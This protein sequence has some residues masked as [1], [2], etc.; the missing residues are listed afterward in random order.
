M[1]ERNPIQ[2]AVRYALTAGVAAS[3]AGVPA[4]V[5]AQTEIETGDVSGEIAEQGLVE[6]TGSR[7][8]RVDIEGPSPVSTITREDIDSTGDISIADVLRSSTYNQ[9]GS[10]RPNSGSSAQSQATIS[11]RGLGAT[12][13]LVLLDGRR[14]AGSPSFGSG[15]AQNLNVVPMAAVERIEV[16]RDGA[17]AVY[18]SDAI[19]GVVNIILRKDYEG[20]QLSAEVGRPTQ[21]GGDENAYS[22][23]GGIT[24]G[25]GNV[26]FALDHSD[27][28][29][30]FN[31]QRTYSGVGLSSFGFP[32]SLSPLHP[33]SG[34]TLA[35]FPDPRCPTSINTDP[36]FPNSQINTGGN[37]RCNFN[38]AATSANIASISRDSIFVNG[39]YQVTEDINFFARGTFTVT[40]S[41]GRY[42]PAPVTAPFPTM[43]AANINN[44]TQPGAV[45]IPGGVNTG[46]PVP[47]PGATDLSQLDTTGDGIP[48]LTGPFDLTV[49]YRNVPGGFRDSNVTTTLYDYLVGFEGT[50]DLLGGLDWDTGFQYSKQTNKDT[51]AGLGFAGSLQAAIDNQSFDVFGINGPT[52][53]N[54]AA[55]FGHT[56]F[57]DELTRIGSGDFTVTF[58]SFNLPAGPVPVA[59]GVEYRDEKFSQDYDAQQNAANV[60]GS[61]GGADVTGARTVFAAYTEA[62]FPIIDSLELN[63]ALRYDSYNDFGTTVNPKVAAGWRPIDSLLI[64]GSW[65]QGFRAPSMNQLYSSPAQSFNNAIDSTR[66]AADPLG[67][68]N[69]RPTVPVTMLPTGNPCLSTQYQNF[70][71]GNTNLD[72]ETSRS[73]NVGFVWS[74][75]D[76]LSVSFDYFN[77]DLTNQIGTLPLQTILDNELAGGPTPLVTRTPT[78]KIFS[79]MANNQNIA[80]TRTK[81]YDVDVQYS[82]AAGNIGDFTT[83]VQTSKVTQYEFDS[84]N[85]LGYGRLPGTFDPDLRAQWN[86]N[87]SRGDFSGA[88]VANYVTSTSDGAGASLDSWTTWDLQFGWQTPW[89]ARV[90]IGARN[91]T[92]EDP[93][94]STALGNPNYSNQLHDAYGRV[95]YIR[96]TQDL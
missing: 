71:G 32:G 60:F 39:N 48:D 84:G 25:K 70:T 85:G 47:F 90:T 65:G 30:I 93:P 57:H 10:F 27:S 26:T 41:F 69:G 67:G 50:T 7:I 73:S 9:F 81:G 87:W 40:D 21:S 82:F 58:D 33:T 34:L 96:Y 64:R 75:L 28:E 11:L 5:S 42:A 62:N 24:S 53:A 3:F 20:M 17:S 19:G 91:L 61:A 15:S 43:S 29:I 92:D 49:W 14:M 56:G 23:V 59:L 46:Y 55:S 86:L 2:D 31:G 80:G 44:P 79:I 37:G 38:Y 51:S 36:M 35:T 8:K 94:I 74:P 13:T 66:C 12:R 88:V 54:I 1:K 6:V 18:G 45:L 89:N 22:L 77:V 16:L 68:P 95:P 76:D 72:A 4:L 78:G 63:V 83:Q 52:N